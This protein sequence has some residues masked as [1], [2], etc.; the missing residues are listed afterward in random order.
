MAYFVCT[1]VVKIRLIQFHWL[2]YDTIEFTA[3]SVEKIK[4]HSVKINILFMK[5]TTR[6]REF[7]NVLRN[8]L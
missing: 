7:L 8:I 4:T 3:L 6:K 5:I 1:F 2:H